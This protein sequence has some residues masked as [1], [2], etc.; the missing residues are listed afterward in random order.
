[1][2]GH[3]VSTHKND[4]FQSF[5]C[6]LHISFEF[7]TTR[8]RLPC[9]QCFCSSKYHFQFCQSSQRASPAQLRS[10]LSIAHCCFLFADV[11]SAQPRL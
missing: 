5:Q 10:S 6:K 7:S 2:L 1:M 11:L 9:E 3:Q 4:T 8:P